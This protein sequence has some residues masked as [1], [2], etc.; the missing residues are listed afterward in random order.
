[1]PRAI[2]RGN[3]H[4]GGESAGH[5]GESKK[6]A[7]DPSDADGGE[8]ARRKRHDAD[9][10]AE[11]VDDE[12]QGERR[13]HAAQA[14]WEMV[15]RMEA[16]RASRRR[17]GRKN[18]N[19][20]P[21]WKRI[22]LLEGDL[23]QRGAR[24]ADAARREK[25]E[26]LAG[27]RAVLAQEEDGRHKLKG[28]QRMWKR[29]RAEAAE[30]DAR[31]AEL[32]GQLGALRREISAA[33]AATAAAA[34]EGLPAAGD[35]SAD[36]RVAAA[37]AEL[38]RAEE[39]VLYVRYF[40]EDRRYIGIHDD[41]PENVLIRKGIL[42]YIVG[43]VQRARAA[44]EDVNLAVIPPNSYFHETLRAP[45]TPAAET[46]GSGTLEKKRPREGP[47]PEDIP[48]EKRRAADPVENR[49]ASALAEDDFFL[50]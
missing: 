39:L 35:V 28:L 34:A 6:P 3:R 45:R 31:V 14:A 16:A 2:Y 7:K 4:P 9:G 40:P 24:Y 43:H 33:A 37:R 42:K 23:A 22:Q 25:E 36:P 32:R 29:R 41:D 10:E 1:M 8:K 48:P 21:T 27:L 5:R 49:A 19:Q 44:H 26:L 46:D 12:Q 30:L 17:R 50:Q 13:V 18:F 47:Y 38:K 15:E 20:L 11:G